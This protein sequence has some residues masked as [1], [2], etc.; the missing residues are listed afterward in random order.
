MQ[1]YHFSLAN[2]HKIILDCIFIKYCEELQFDCYKNNCTL[3]KVL[4]YIF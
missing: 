3:A 1:N 4:D 2:L